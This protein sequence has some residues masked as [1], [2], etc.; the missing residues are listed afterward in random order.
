MKFSEFL[1]TLSPKDK[2]QL[3]K[4]NRGKMPSYSEYAKLLD[5]NQHEIVTDKTYR[6]DKIRKKRDGTIVSVEKRNRIPSD[7]Y[8]DIVEQQSAF[9]FGNRVIWSD[10]DQKNE[11]FLKRFIKVLDNAKYSSIDIKLCMKLK[12]WGEACEIWYGRE[13]AEEIEG[14]TTKTKFRC[15]VYSPEDSLLY[16]YFDN[17]GDLKAFGRQYVITDQNGDDKVILDIYTD[18]E[19][20]RFEEKNEEFAQ[21]G[22]PILHGLK[23]IPVVYVSQKVPSYIKVK[24]VI[25]RL[26]LL[27]SN[28]ADTNDYHGSPT[29][30]AKGKVNGFS[31]K[32]EAGRILEVDGDAQVDYLSYDSMNESLKFE[33][34]TL[35]KEM[36]YHSK[37]VDLSLNNLKGI[38]NISGRALRTL[39]TLPHLQV[40]L[41]TMLIYSPWMERRA[42]IIK[43]YLRSIDT[44]N[45]AQY[46]KMKPTA[47]IKPFMVDDL[48][49]LIEDLTTATGG[50]GIMSV[51][52]AVSMLNVV[53]NTTDETNRILNEQNGGY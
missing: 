23:K 25:E 9:A 45:E 27:Q 34:E 28:H 7:Y 33:R 44:T 6:P 14:I 5:I 30:I 15:D 40:V 19:L 16:P 2:I 13:S 24:D 10:T 20:V 37:T 12:A 52:T 47:T 53:E 26:E 43:D 51:Q 18:E 50:K 17:T 32:G 41:D 11:I 1:G 48:T 21:I 3:L 31:G 22:Q 35:E 36:R 8:N 49:T 42:S 46:N 4:K 38:G 39:F 29:I